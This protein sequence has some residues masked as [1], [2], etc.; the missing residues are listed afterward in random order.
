LQIHGWREETFDE[1]R[2]LSSDLNIQVSETIG[3]DEQPLETPQGT[4]A[5]ATQN[6]VWAAWIAR[7]VLLAL[8]GA[9]AWHTW[10]H[11]GD[12][13]IDNGREL[14]V[15]AS[16]L[17]GK[18]LYRD[19]WYMYGPLAPYVQALLFWVWGIHL[20]VLYS[21]GLAL[22]IGSAL[23]VFET[24]RQFDLGLLPSIV[25]S[26]MFLLEAFY[27]SIFNFIFPY[28][29]AATLASFLGLACLYFVVRHAAGMRR[30]HL[31]MAAVSGGLALLTKQEFGAACMVL[32][33]LEVAAVTLIYRSWRELGRNVA[34]L[35]AG[36]SPAM[37]VY[38]WFTWKLSARV[39]FFDNWI[40]TP[41]TYYMRTFAK[42]TMMS[43]GFRFIPRE[44]MSSIGLAALVMTFWFALAAVNTAAIKKRRFQSRF[45]GMVLLLDILIGAMIVL[46][47][48]GSDNFLSKFLGQAVFPKGL[49]FL[50][51]FFIGQAVWKLWRDPESRA[52][53]PEAALGI[54][55]TLVSVRV[56]LEL[57]PSP[58]N[59]AVFFNVPL[60][61]IFIILVTRTIRRASQSLETKQR[62]LLVGFMLV[63]EVAI[64]A[65]TLFPNPRW[66]PA[67]FTTQFGTFYT[68]KDVTILFPQIISFM[69]THTRN[70]ND[71][72]VLPEPPSLYVFAGM[73]SP[74]PW[75]SLLPGV[76]D[77][78]Q[79]QEFIKEATAN[80]TRYVLVSNRAVTEY[81]V[82]PFGV[83]FD[84]II[85]QWI[86]SDFEKISQFGPLPNSFPG[87]YI[88]SVF[89]RRDLRHPK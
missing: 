26:L 16:I 61:L 21:L 5:G 43:Q 42:H 31:A 65:V 73:Q 89:E 84:Q 60:F 72:L 52:G 1:G 3:R 45:T 22:T 83:G 17:H 53:L 11:W 64:L 38:G 40:S 78:E 79:E 10:G 9:M 85:G 66:L 47:V 19:L 54:Y 2:R 51:L 28:S 8:A 34:I 69:K 46:W 62:N 20:A 80:D 41:G 27:P 25:P 7:G 57:T 67:P 82:A 24:A 63:A 4:N 6:S 37:A 77:L 74:T 39:I 58:S 29:Y 23:L 71:I 87:A 55:A 35:L 48:R 36:L 81:G 15:P 56:M 13:Q 14:Y 68:R 12:F 59:Y 49:F 30:M 18:M 32:L 86:H 44:L 75:Y 50:G 33:A 88:M 76:L 70:R